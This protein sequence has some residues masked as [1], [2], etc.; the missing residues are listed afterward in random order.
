MGILSNNQSTSYIQWCQNGTAFE[1][2]DLERFTSE[3]LP[4]YFKA[5]RYPSFKR[6]LYRWGFQMNGEHGRNSFYNENFLK[7]RKE[8]IPRM[9]CHYSQKELRL[10]QAKKCIRKKFVESMLKN[11]R[12]PL[13]R[14]MD[15]NN[16]TNVQ[17]RSQV[18]NVLFEQ[19][20]ESDSVRNRSSSLQERHHFCPATT[21]FSA[22]SSRLSS[23][24]SKTYQNECLWET[25]CEWKIEQPTSFKKIIEFW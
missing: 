21:S 9:Y 24:I 5:S 13:Q 23:S 15:Y 10:K 12:C 6:K 20:Y 16:T 18:S 17:I 14:N 4:V 8:L 7:Y 25:H 1:I 19:N 11:E 3:I 22:S 2:L